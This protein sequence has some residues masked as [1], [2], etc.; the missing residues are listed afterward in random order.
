MTF[1]NLTS[2]SSV[3]SN[4]YVPTALGRD[5]VVNTATRYE[6][7]GPGIE[8]WWGRAF[9]QQFRTAQGHIQSSVQWVPGLFSGDKAAKEWR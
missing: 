9:P 8:S 7:D 2:Y 4:I 6:M 3:V 1:F 5:T